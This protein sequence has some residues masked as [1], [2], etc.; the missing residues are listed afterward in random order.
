MA[1]LSKNKK[2]PVS[3]GRRPSKPWVAGSNP[4]GRARAPRGRFSQRRAGQDIRGTRT[5][6]GGI[7]ATVTKA[8]PP[9]TLP[10]FD[11]LYFKLEP[12]EMRVSI[13]EATILR[14]L[15]NNEDGDVVNDGADDE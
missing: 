15:E 2:S 5:A 14:Y 10:S 11:P 13:L 6:T 1:M 3:Q 7:L 8:P 4:A 12:Q 9:T